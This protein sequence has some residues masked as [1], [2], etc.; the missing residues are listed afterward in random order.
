MKPLDNPRIQ[1]QDT[2]GTSLAIQFDHF[3]VSG[4]DWISTFKLILAFLTF[5]PKTIDELFNVELEENGG[6]ESS[7]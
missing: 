1:V 6:N 5:G 4:E 7:G 2:K 3:D